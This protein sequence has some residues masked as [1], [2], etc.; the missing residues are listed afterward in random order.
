M[1]YFGAS[2]FFQHVVANIEEYFKLLETGEFN[3]F[4][5]L[6]D[7]FEKVA[8]EHDGVVSLSMYLL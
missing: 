8:F 7:D 1:L 5:G 2:T 4:G 3:T 6:T